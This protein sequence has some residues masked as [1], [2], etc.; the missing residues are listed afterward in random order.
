MILMEAVNVKGIFVQQN[1]YRH[2]ALP[3][4]CLLLLRLPAPILL[5]TPCFL[6]L[7][8]GSFPPAA[9]WFSLERLEDRKEGRQAGR[10][11][12]SAWRKAGED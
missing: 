7:D 3:C 5:P 1:H 6:S 12:V 11:A 4:P 10:Q 8:L 9:T 2:R